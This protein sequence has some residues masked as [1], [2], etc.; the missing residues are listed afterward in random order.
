MKRLTSLIL[1]LI[2]LGS[3]AQA[4][5]YYYQQRR[6]IQEALP[7]TSTDIVMLGDSQM[8]IPEL[9]EL[10]G[11]LRI[12]NRGISGDVTDGVIQRLPAIIQ[13]HPAK[14]F[15]RVGVNDVSHNLSA[16]H[17]A[18]LILEIIKMIRQGT[19]QT[20]LYVESCLPIN[21]AKGSYRSLD[22]KEQVIRDINAL[23]EGQAEAQGFTWLNSYPLFTDADGNLDM[24]YSNDGLHL[25][26]N[27]YA[28]YKT[29]LQPYINE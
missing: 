5:N 7:I 25:M 26:G 17:I 14:I 9:T 11:D 24:R 13:G 18:G 1:A 4:Q 27:G 12:K 21:Q 8:D 28:R 19:P 29:F 6:S 3:L 15:L 22:G 16:T 20:R 2:C 23:I 10:F